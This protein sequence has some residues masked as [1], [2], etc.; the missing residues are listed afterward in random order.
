[1]SERYSKEQREAAEK[2]RDAFDLCASA[3]LE[4]LVHWADGFYLNKGNT[5]NREEMLHVKS[6]LIFTLEEYPD[7]GESW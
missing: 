4:G 6:N 3:G 5:S 7:C 1:M 2:L